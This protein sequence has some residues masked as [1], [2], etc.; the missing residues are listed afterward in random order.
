MA[1]Q[2]ASVVVNDIDLDEAND[3]VAEITAKGGTAQAND[4]DINTREGAGALIG[5]CLSGSLRS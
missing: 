3:V 4:S 2:G 5:L 1:E